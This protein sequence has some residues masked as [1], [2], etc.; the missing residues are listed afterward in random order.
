AWGSYSR[1][2]VGDLEGAEETARRARSGADRLGEPLPACISIGCLASA[3]QLRGDFGN[4]LELIEEAIRL[5]DRSEG[6]FEL[7][8]KEHASVQQHAM[9]NFYLVE[10]DRSAEAL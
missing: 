4:A 9:R 3:S 5:S 2:L 10:L 7:R 6:R 8:L 1:I